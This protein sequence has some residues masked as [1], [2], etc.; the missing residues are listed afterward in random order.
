MR[1]IIVGGGEIGFALAQALAPSH[2]VVVIDHAPEVADR[3]GRLDVQFL[4]GT[5]T[6]AELLRRAGIGEADVLVACTGLDE[7]NIV[8][9]AVGNRLGSPRTFC[10]VSREEFLQFQ[11]DRQGLEQFGIDRVVW[12]E[13]QLAEDIERIIRAPGALDAEAFADGAIRMFEYLLEAGSGVVNRRI[14]D[15]HLPHGSLVVAV[16]RGDSVF[17][18]RG[19][20]VLL[21]GDRAVVMG[22]PDALQEVRRRITTTADVGRQRVTIIGGGDVGLRLA[23]RLDGAPD[24]Q[25]TIIERNPARGELLASRLRHVLV[26]NGD[27]TD[28][29]LLEAEDIGRSDV[30]VS[31]IDNDERN[32]LA[33]LLGRQLGARRIITRVSRQANLR[34]FERVGIDV[35]L[36]ARGAAV[37]S[38]LHQIQGGPTRLLAV[39][40]QG[41]GRI[42]ELEVPP[43]YAPRRLRELDPPRNSI[44]GAIVRDSRAIV[45]RGHDSIQPGDRLLVFTTHAAAEKVRNYFTS[46][47]A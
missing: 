6:S 5:G 44:I 1:I 24:L 40:E 39:V 23:E 4:L 16:R 42:L 21:P 26:L 30:L 14:A 37:A 47:K 25:V 7:V 2:E 9:C 35:A 29:E 36:S 17:I 22:T 43:G 20:S 27:G 3:F 34:L 12:P 33:S 8:A 15:L 32:L 41:A 38:V 10:F 46:V 13:A 18:P 31:V 11:E 19:D 28:L 45:P